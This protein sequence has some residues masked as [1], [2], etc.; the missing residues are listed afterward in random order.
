MTFASASLRRQRTI[1]RIALN[2]NV[3]VPRAASFKEDSLLP[4]EEVP[5]ACVDHPDHMLMFTLLLY[6]LTVTDC[7]ARR[8]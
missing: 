7:S 2:E 5:F 3:R 4:L 6:A 1:H 8:L